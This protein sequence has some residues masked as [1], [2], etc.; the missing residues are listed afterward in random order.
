MWGIESP[1]GHHD[2]SMRAFG[3]DPEALFGFISLPKGGLE[4]ARGADL[5][6]M[7]VSALAAVPFFVGERPLG[8]SWGS[9]G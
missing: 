3:V 6:P 9:P 4:R 2:E 5:K 7:G 8:K 1:L